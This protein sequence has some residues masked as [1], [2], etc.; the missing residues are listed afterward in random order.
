MPK[1]CWDRTA[2]QLISALAHCG[3]DI[4]SVLGDYDPKCRRMDP[5]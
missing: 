2:G 5:L 4:G 1:G 3:G